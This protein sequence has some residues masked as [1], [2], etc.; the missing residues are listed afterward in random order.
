MDP[1]C[2]MA[3]TAFSTRLIRASRSSAPRAWT[4]GHRTQLL[5]DHDRRAP[6]VALRP[7]R[8]HDLDRLADDVPEVHAL[9]PAID[10]P[11]REAPDAADRLDAV[12]D[13]LLDRRQAPL[14][15]LGRGLVGDELGV[16]EDRLEQ[17]GEVVGHAHGQLTEGGELLGPGQLL[18]PP[19]LLG[20][21]ADDQE[22]PGLVAPAPGDGRAGRGEVLD[23][24][25]ALRLEAQYHRPAGPRGRQHRLELDHHGRRHRVAEELAARLVGLR[26]RTC[27]R[28]RGST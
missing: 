3:S 2:G 16:P 7:A 21:V 18:L 5:A 23:G 11:A 22:E 27:A 6:Q 28:P 19:A 15:A 14:E 10:V 26:G 13:G 4:G 12:A 17:V 8:P 9:E 24:A 1:P 20:D 25:V